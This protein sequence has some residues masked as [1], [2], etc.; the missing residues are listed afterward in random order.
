MAIDFPNIRHM[1]VLL[2]AVRTGSVSTAAE[3]CHLSQPAA[4]QAIA[5]LE[6]D[7]GTPLLIRKSRELIP[8]ECGSVFSS[9]VEAALAHLRRG[10][11]A[12]LRA[13]G[14]ET[15]RNGA[16]FDAQV[17]AAQLR[18]LIAIAASGSFT[19]AAKSLGVSQ[20]TVHRSARGLEALAGITFFRATAVGVELTG[21]AQAF[22]L[23]AKL[24]QS[25]IRQ[26]VEEIGRLLGEDLGTFNLGSLPLARTSI[27]PNAVHALVSSTTGVQIRVV[28]GRYAHLLRSLREGDLDCLIGALRNPA[29]ADDVTEEVL[30]HDELGIVAHPT[31]P[32]AQRERVTLDDTLAYPWVAPPKDTPAGNYLFETLRIHERERTPVRVVSSSLAFL[33]GVLACGDYLT[34]ISR[35][36]IQVEIL[37]GHFTVLPIALQGHF[38]AIG[39]TFRTG[40]RPT[41]TQARFIDYLRR[42]S[43]ES[44]GRPVIADSLT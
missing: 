7:L 4:T 29:P 9:R 21:A 12:A 37:D 24:A 10:A 15:R 20:P 17:T 28:D 31:H 44:G 22:V 30:F 34:I 19:V 33:R 13:G 26:G 2:A 39:L 27:V 41:A 35:H 3:R 11:R 43:A 1:R 36:Q 6:S 40:W 42:F 25:E 16:T 32:L 5:R 14:A 38:R 8:T 18:A 23:G